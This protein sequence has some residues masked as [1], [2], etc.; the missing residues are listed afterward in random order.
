MGVVALQANRTFLDLS[1]LFDFV[2]EL[3]EAS[4][5]ADKLAMTVH[6]LPDGISDHEGIGDR[7]RGQCYLRSHRPAGRKS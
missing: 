4:W 7:C 6:T 1:V 2:S 3:R 5:L